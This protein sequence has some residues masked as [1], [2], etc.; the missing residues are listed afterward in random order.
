MPNRILPSVAEFSRHSGDDVL[1]H[2]NDGIPDGIRATVDRASANPL[3]SDMHKAL[4]PRLKRV[5]ARLSHAIEAMFED[6]H[7]HMRV[8]DLA[9]DAGM[10][11]MQL[12]RHFE[13]AGLSS[14]KKL[15]VAAKVLRAC[16]YLADPTYSVRD[17]AK[18]LGYLNPRI[19]ARH[20][21]DV[22]GL[23][24]SRLR[25]RL[26]AESVVERLLAWLDLG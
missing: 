21:V 8:S 25:T 26:A 9:S 20:C 10:S 17:V 19:F 7:Y 18:K 22:S 15:L 5:P 4:A 16:G 23:T 24:P 3:S 11:S 13:I 14:P 1:P 6:P 12:Y 2:R